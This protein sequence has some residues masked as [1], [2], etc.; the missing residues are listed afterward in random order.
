MNWGTWSGWSGVKDHCRI[1][2]VWISEGSEFL[3]YGTPAGSF[4][5]K[6]FSEF[7]NF[8]KNHMC[9]KGRFIILF[10]TNF[11]IAK[12]LGKKFSAKIGHKSSTKGSPIEI[13]NL[14]LL[15]NFLSKNFSSGELV[16]KE[17]SK[18]WYSHLKSRTKILSV[19]WYSIRFLG[20][21]HSISC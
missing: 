6:L 13:S 16:S 19:L 8:I 20:R 9:Y 1:P 7:R 10:D 12:F 17:L 14:F 21:H 3:S 18:R 5:Q 11:P 4:F 15:K 2:L